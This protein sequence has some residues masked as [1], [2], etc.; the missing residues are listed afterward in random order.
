METDL[1]QT[2]GLSEDATAQQIKESYRS[3]VRLHHPDANPD[4]REE[5]EA[6]M[7]DVL[8]A[9]ATLSDPEKRK[10]YD[11]DERIR[12]VERIQQTSDV[13]VTHHPTNHGTTSSVPK[14]LIGRVRIVMGDSLEVFAQKL[15]LSEMALTD[16]EKRDAVPTS[17]IQL[18][19]FTNQVEMAAKKLASVGKVEEANELKSLL[20]RKKNRNNYR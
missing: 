5:S 16:F 20:T 2:L 10:R 7:K 12:E 6:L 11:R 14:S 4:N 15:G 1:Y 9:Y 13:R 3:L 17:P 8:R 19:T 18:R